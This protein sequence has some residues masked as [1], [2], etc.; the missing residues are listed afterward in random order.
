MLR[1]FLK[2][3]LLIAILA[4]LAI[5]VIIAQK[6]FFTP[7]KSS[8]KPEKLEASLQKL[9]EVYSKGEN[10][11]SFAEANRIFY[12]EGKVRVVIELVNEQ[13]EVP[14][15]YGVVIEKRYKN[16]V[17]ALVPINN[18]ESLSNSPLVKFIRTPKEPILM[19]NLV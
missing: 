18:L 2:Y 3:G 17:Q 6:S 1:K 8:K 7:F 4:S 11:E 10:V 12:E 13:A 16:M 15:G 5:S 19:K 9:I 14:E